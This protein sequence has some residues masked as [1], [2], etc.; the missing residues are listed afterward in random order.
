[1]QDHDETEDAQ[2][3]PAYKERMAAGKSLRKQVARSEHGQWQ[4][5]KRRRDVV[6]LLKESD[7]GRVPELVPIRYGRM[8]QSPF[9]FFRGA[10]NIMAHDLAGTP[11]SGLR[12]QSCGDSHLMNFGEF[13]TPERNIVFD[14]NDFD[15]TLP[16]PW[17]WD[18]KRLAAS[19]MVAARHLGFPEPKC[20]L[21]ARSAVAGYRAKM[22][23]F[24][25]MSPLQRWYAK[26][27]VQEMNML[28]RRREGRRQSE[29]IVTHARATASHLAVKTR[30]SGG[31]WHIIDN[32]PL[33]RHPEKDS[34]LENDLRRF[35]IDYRDSLSNDRKV[36]LDRYEVVDV[37][38]KVVGVGSVGT[39]CAVALL[40]ANGR[41]PLLLQFKE[42]RASV[43]EP[44]HGKSL[45][46]NH[47][48]RVVEGQKL[49]QSASDIFLG[50]ARSSA[51][52][53]Y[54][55]RQPRDMKGSIDIETTQFP[56]LRDYAG[57][58]GWALARAHAKSGD[59]AAISGYMGKGEAFD[60]AI[61]G[62]AQAYADQTEAD[63]DVLKKAVAAGKV[64][65]VS[66]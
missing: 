10:A 37:A 29:A 28:W 49:M 44:Y 56:E 11:V 17:E 39:R 47:G 66:V 15:E 65:A 2:S 63:Y 60:Q 57:F 40:M 32:P 38:M 50:W 19:V 52:M 36:L 59:P 7:K 62:F 24:A 27:D 64:V 4:P 35:F 21:A 54:Y 18:V 20:L 22:I 33:L 31:Q 1:M 8:L 61:A 42:A 23:E 55:I 14:V 13:G 53:D 25:K 12:V 46:A 45:Y 43:L 16:G 5:P 30:V 26:I 48:R 3:S 41:D 6:A 51:G 34:L 9:T 58:C